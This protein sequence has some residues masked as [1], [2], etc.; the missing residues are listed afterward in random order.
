[1]S[2]DFRLTRTFKYREHY[3]LAVLGE[4]FNALNIANLSG[5]SATLNSTAFGQP[6][7]RV[8]QTFGS[9]G[10][11]AFQVGARARFLAQLVRR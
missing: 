9:G 5:Y 8:I 2:Q 7:E 10:P 11:R 4:V 3:S 1:M 6:T